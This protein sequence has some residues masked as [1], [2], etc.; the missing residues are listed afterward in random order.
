MPNTQ[1]FKSASV[2]EP[3]H[4]HRSSKKY[5]WRRA[6]GKVQNIWL[7]IDGAAAAHSGARHNRS[8]VVQF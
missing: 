7:V 4:H 1:T 6:L 8:W 5:K 2:E 3:S